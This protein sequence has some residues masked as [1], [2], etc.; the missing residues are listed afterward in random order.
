MISVGSDTMNK[1]TAY[2]LNDKLKATDFIEG[3]NLLK[4]I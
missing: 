2:F 4:L 1:N 3:V